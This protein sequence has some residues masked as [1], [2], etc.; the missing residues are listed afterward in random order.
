MA[1][2]ISP[3]IS[4]VDNAAEALEFYQSVLGGTLNI[5]RPMPTR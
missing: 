5:P 1:F 4:F 2:K 3:Y